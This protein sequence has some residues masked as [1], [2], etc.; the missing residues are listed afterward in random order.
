MDTMKTENIPW[1]G[2]GCWH[3]V[4]PAFFCDISIASTVAVAMLNDLIDKGFEDKVCMVFK[5]KYNALGVFE[6][7]E[8]VC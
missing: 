5:K 4:F 6:G 2:I 7:Y 8:K 3:P 1:D